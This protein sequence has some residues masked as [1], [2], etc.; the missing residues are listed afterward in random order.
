MTDESLENPISE[1]LQEE[2]SFEDRWDT[3]VVA[4]SNTNA[5][6]KQAMGQVD[7][8]SANVVKAEKAVENANAA[9]T[10]S[11]ANVGEVITSGI[12]VT[13]DLIGQLQ[14]HLVELQT[15]KSSI[16]A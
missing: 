8:N 13:N 4:L 6:I 16:S 1:E 15:A 11:K 10:D 2:V 9:F 3:S 12:Q 7:V 14:G 5:A